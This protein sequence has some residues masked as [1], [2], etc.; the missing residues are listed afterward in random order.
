MVGVQ[1][2]VWAQGVAFDLG[3]TKRL[4]GAKIPFR[5]GSISLRPSKAD[6]ELWMAYWSSTGIERILIAMIILYVDDLFYLGRQEAIRAIH[7]WVES[8]WPCSP[9]EWAHEEGGAR[10]LGCEIR[11]G[12]SG[13]FVISQLGYIL[14]LLRSHEMQD[15]TPTALP[16]PREWIVDHLSEEPENFS[17]EELRFG[18]RCV[19]ELLWLCLR[20]RPDLQFVVG[21]MSQWVARQPVRVSRIAMKV[22]GYLSKT[23]DMKLVLGRTTNSNTA[24][25][26]ANQPVLGPDLVTLIGYSDASFS[27]SSGR[28]FGSAVVTVNNSAIAWRASKQ[29]FVTLSVMESEL[30]EATETALLL[31]CVGALLDELVSGCVPRVLRCDNSAATAM[32]QGGPGSWR[33][34][35][36]RVRSSYIRERVE[37]SELVVEHVQGQWQ[38]ADLGTKMPI[39][40]VA[41]DL[42]LRRP[43]F[44]CHTSLRTEDDDCGLHYHHDSFGSGGDWC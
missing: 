18:Q 21:H 2:F 3:G 32:L 1:A 24:A 42:G 13:E 26:E 41:S 31:E 27:P 22:L 6:P 20:T 23:R 36:L 37:R 10:Y 43:S 29:A 38:W 39:V 12:S 16:C 11:Q 28:S 8:D 4:A 25:A 9:L 33:T 35:H 17:Q 7:A 44:Q 19:G 15:V 14:D 5:D 40:G 30:L 34:R